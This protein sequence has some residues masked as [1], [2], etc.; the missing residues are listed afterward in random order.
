MKML[1]SKLISKS[2]EAVEQRVRAM[3]RE[4]RV[5]SHIRDYIVII[6]PPFVFIV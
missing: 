5:Q 1:R 4:A 2:G 6:G 3:I